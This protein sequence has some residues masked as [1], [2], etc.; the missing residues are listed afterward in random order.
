MDET[1]QVAMFVRNDGGAVVC[2]PST[3]DGDGGLQ[4][5]VDAGT[6]G[7][8]AFIGG[9]SPGSIGGLHREWTGEILLGSER[10]ARSAR[11]PRLRARRT[12]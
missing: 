5:E 7:D 3:F 1:H 6:R 8:S 10:L 12:A 4:R 11:L 2:V 9:G